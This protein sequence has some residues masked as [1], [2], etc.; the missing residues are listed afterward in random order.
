MFHSNLLLN[1]IIFVYFYQIFFR[2]VQATGSRTD[3][4]SDRLLI[5]AHSAQLAHQ[6]ITGRI[7]NLKHNPGANSFGSSSPKNPED[8]FF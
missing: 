1:N 6:P 2:L 7:E 8:I 4:L 5:G 3:P